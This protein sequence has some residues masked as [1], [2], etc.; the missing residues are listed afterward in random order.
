MGDYFF[1]SILLTAT[2]LILLIVLAVPCSYT[3][4]RFKFR[5]VGVI[6]LIF[7]AGLFINTNYIVLPLY[8][9]IYRIG[10]AAMTNNY[11]TVTVLYASTSLSFSI[12]LLSSYFRGLSPS[13]EEAA[14]IDGCGYFKTFLYICAPLAMPSILT[15]ILFNFLSYWNEYMLAQT[16]PFRGKFHASRGASAHHARSEDGQR[17]GQNVRRPSHRHHSRAHRLCL[18]AGAADEGDYGGR[19][20]RLTLLVY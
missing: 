11:V 1:H 17:P 4:S 12:Y 19:H 18:R 2:S 8:L 13:Y 5:G 3:L 20:Q 10:G 14:K 15:V 7:M 9:M 6:T 16:L